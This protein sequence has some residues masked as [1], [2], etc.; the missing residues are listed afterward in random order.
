MTKYVEDK[1]K[2]HGFVLIGSSTDKE[3]IKKVDKYLIYVYDFYTETYSVNLKLRGD[4]HYT[5]IKT[6]SSLKKFLQSLEKAKFII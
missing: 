4:I 3:Y 2:A 1:L 6:F 5:H